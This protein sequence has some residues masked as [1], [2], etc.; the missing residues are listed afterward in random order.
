MG[1]ANHSKRSSGEDVNS[2]PDLNTEQAD[3]R[4][5]RSKWPKDRK[6]RLAAMSKAM[7]QFISEYFGGITAIASAMNVTPADVN[8]VINLDPELVELKE[9]AVNSVEDLL[10][11][12]MT[13]LAMNTK[14]SAPVKFLLERMFPDKYGSK[15]GSQTKKGAGFKAPSEKPDNLPSAINVKPK[16]N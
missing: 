15:S 6:L 8:E 16:E 1:L 3:Q 9:I 12:R 11:D 2:S 4:A 13:Y 5:R 7:P 10:L 14:S